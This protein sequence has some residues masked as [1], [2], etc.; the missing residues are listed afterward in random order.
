[1]I[2]NS[3]RKRDTIER[4]R[5]IYWFEGIRSAM[6]APTAY[7]VERMVE[8]ESFRVSKDGVP[9]HRNKWTSYQ[10]GK[11]TPSG[12]LITRVNQHVAG[13]GRE[14]NHI[15]WKSLGEGADVLLHAR[16]WLRQLSPELQILIFEEDDQ[17]RI[18]RR[19]QFLGKIE[20]RANI[21][22]LACLTILL[23]MNLA[24][25]EYQ[26]AWD[27]AASTFR[28]L[29][30]LGAQFKKRRIADAL[31]EVYVE[32][33]LRASR[34]NG[35]RFYLEKYD[36]SFLAGIL[37]QCSLN[38]ISAGGRSRSWSEEVKHMEMYLDGKFGFDEKFIFDPL[39]GPDRDLGPLSESMQAMLD[40]RV[41]LMRRGIE[42]LYGQRAKGEF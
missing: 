37:Y 18:H 41:R 19:R 31:F 35:E 4:I 15:L 30:I 24:L 3:K 34:W 1:M 33:I 25:G 10:N 9:F 40:Q 8:P 26:Y 29:L 27:L 22:A 20:R 6:R 17:F 36:F 11:H 38:A 7:A 14:L 21:D 12:V 28:M 16:E 2:K 5:T 32:R 42:K 39:I 23:R 13:S